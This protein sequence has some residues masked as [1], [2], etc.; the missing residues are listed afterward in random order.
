M[1]TSAAGMMQL[2]Q[3]RAGYPAECRNLSIQREVQLTGLAVDLVVLW[4]LTGG[5][6]SPALLNR[7]VYPA[8]TP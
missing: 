2:A 8:P 6:A 3:R 4:L 5:A 7:I 1:A